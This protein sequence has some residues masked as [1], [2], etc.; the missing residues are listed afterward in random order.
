MHGFSLIMS[1]FLLIA[2][3]FQAWQIFRIR[4]VEPWYANRAA[5]FAGAHGLMLFAMAIGL[6]VWVIVF[7]A[8][9]PIAWGVIDAMAKISRR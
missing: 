1:V 3:A 9:P 4:S 8:L 6:P 2:A 5:H 7:S